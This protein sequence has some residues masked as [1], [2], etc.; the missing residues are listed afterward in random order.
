MQHSRI[1]TSRLTH[2]I[3]LVYCPHPLLTL[4]LCDNLSSVLNNN[5]IGL[6]GAIAAH[7]IPTIRSLDHLHS[8]IV[9]ATGL[10]SL[11]E[12]VE[13]AVATVRPQPAVAIVT[14]VEHIAVLT[15]LITAIFLGA[16]AK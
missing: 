4:K 11:L 9:L 6:K 16:H 7:T 8:D 5:L 15:V 2:I 12:L 14:L 3:G 10:G 13:A 1:V